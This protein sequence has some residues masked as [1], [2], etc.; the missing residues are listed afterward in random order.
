M[1]T[2]WFDMDGTIYE[3]YRIPN[4]LERV[5]EMD[6]SVFSDGFPRNDYDRI[7]IAVEALIEQGWQVGVITWAPKGATMD[8][9]NEVS[10]VKFNWLCKFFPALANGKFACIPYGESK[11]QFLID[12]GEARTLNILV[13][14]NKY[15]RADWRKHGEQFKT[16]NATRSFVRELEGLV[17]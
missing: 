6:T 4:W 11:A 12:M 16:I 13:D 7:D 10:E 15:V 1:N 3:L 17:M 5:R 8:E 2:I 14:D 9:I